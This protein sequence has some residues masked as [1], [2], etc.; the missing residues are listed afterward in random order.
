M[1]SADDRL[2]REQGLEARIASI[3]MPEIG[4]LGFR[5][6]RVRL[7]QMNGLTLQI[8]AERPDGSMSVEDCE[9]LSNAISPVLDIEDPIEQAYHLEVSSPG[10]DRPLVRVTDFDDWNGHVAKL[11]TA[12]IVDGRKR[13]KGR[14]IKVEDGKVEFRRDD[15]GK[16]ED[17][18]FTIALDDIADAKLVLSDDLIREA[19][20]RDKALRKANGIADDEDTARDN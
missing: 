19:L 8:M 3:I 7:S 14:I 2:I 10:I 12:R 13:F 20:R 11:E 6:V 16:D 5:L 4:T 1:S 18:S 15:S 9:E 17:P